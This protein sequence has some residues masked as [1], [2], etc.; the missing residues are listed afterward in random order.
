VG[1]LAQRYRRALRAFEA[2]EKQLERGLSDRDMFRMRFAVVFEHLGVAWDDPSLPAR[3]LPEDWP[4]AA[5]RRLA[6]RLYRRLSPGAI[7]FADAVL[8]DVLKRKPLRST[9]K[10]HA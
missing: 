4:G 3:L 9:E 7:R 8:A 6:A 10:Q 5:S 1:K 2:L